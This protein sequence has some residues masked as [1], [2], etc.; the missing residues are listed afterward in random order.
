MLGI[1]NGL[2][3]RKLHA[4]SVGH[5]GL[6]IQ[7]HNRRVYIKG[8]RSGGGIFLTY[9]PG[10]HTTRRSQTSVN[11][12][13]GSFTITNGGY[14]LATFNLER[15]NFPVTFRRAIRQNGVYRGG[16]FMKNTKRIVSGALI[17]SGLL[18]V[19][20]A[21]AQADWRDRNQRHCLRC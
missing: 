12:V 7:R 15:I 18:L 4:K 20:S 5:F 16:F 3:S 19:S 17:V 13:R 6:P 21:T 10:K 1:A 9:S 8:I 14:R 2:L 11:P